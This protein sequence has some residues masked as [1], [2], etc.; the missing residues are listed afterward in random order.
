MRRG[1][2]ALR[3]YSRGFFCGKV[4]T[5]TAYKYTE[6][7]QLGLVRFWGREDERKVLVDPVRAGIRQ[8]GDTREVGI[9]ATEVADG[10]RVELGLGDDV[11]QLVDIVGALLKMGIPTR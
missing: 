4:K 3:R 7:L 10:E 1:T 6:G 2:Q 9:H 8:R 5:R 11:V